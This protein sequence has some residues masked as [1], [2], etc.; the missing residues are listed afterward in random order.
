MLTTDKA[1]S[2]DTIVQST[3]ACLVVFKKKVE[4][5]DFFFKFICS[6][7]M[8]VIRAERSTCA[9]FFFSWT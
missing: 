9:L 6:A 4:I 7:G 3:Q 5:I 1:P 8:N 2:C